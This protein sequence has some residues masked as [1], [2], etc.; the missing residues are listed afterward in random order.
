[1]SSCADFFSTFCPRLDPHPPLRP[2]RKPK[3]GNRPCTLPPV[4]RRSC[5]RRSPRTNEPAA[6]SRLLGH[7]A[8]HRTDDGCST[9]LPVR[10]DPALP[11]RGAT[12]TAHSTSKVD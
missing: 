11:Y 8:G 10:P 12:L 9:L 1:M 2:V 3:T 4:A 6:L 7:H 5:L